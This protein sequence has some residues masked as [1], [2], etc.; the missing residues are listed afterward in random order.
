MTQHSRWFSENPSKAWGEKF[1]LLYSPVWM[2]AFGIFQRSR[3][4]DRMGD[5]GNL[6]VTAAIFLPVWLIP[7]LRRDET[8]LG[9]PWYRTYWFKFNLWIFI[10][11]WVG[12]Y[13]LTEYFFDVMGMVYNYP[14]L[15]WSFD[16]ALL[17]SGKQVVP[18]M[19]YL[20]AHYFFVTYHS[21]AVVVMRRVRTSRLGRWPLAR[22]VTV[23]AAAWCWAWA[24]LFLTTSPQVADQF[25][26][27]DMAWVLRWGALYYACY[28]IVSFPLVARLDEQAEENWTLGRTALEALAAGM[29]TFTLLDLATQAIGARFAVR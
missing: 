22:V 20:H 27:E 7:A 1:F 4:G 5:A 24:E 25:R 26:Y 3:L 18:V 6:L 10:Y 23:A 16:A 29:L 19:M 2:V 15:R 21:T 9:R 17:G 12:T 13:F 28:F 11:A 14:H 8:A